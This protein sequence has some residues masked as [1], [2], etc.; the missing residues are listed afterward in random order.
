MIL[1]Q[2]DERDQMKGFGVVDIKPA[3]VRQGNIRARDVAGFRIK[4]AKRDG[5]SI[6]PPMFTSKFLH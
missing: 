4:T 2:F 5:C 3:R 1:P 6:M